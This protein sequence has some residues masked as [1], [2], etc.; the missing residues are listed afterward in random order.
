MNT[1]AAERLWKAIEELWNRI[2]EHCE[3]VKNSPF[4]F[5]ACTVNPKHS[6]VSLPTPSMQLELENQARKYFEPLDV[7]GF[8]FRYWTPP[9]LPIIDGPKVSSI[10]DYQMTCEVPQYDDAW[11]RT[12]LARWLVFCPNVSEFSS[13][14]KWFVPQI[15]ALRFTPVLYQNIQ[16]SVQLNQI[17]ICLSKNPLPFFESFV[18]EYILTD[19]SLEMS[20][21]DRKKYQQ[22]KKWRELYPEVISIFE[23]KRVTLQKAYIECRKQAPQTRNFKIKT[24]L[25]GFATYIEKILIA[26]SSLPDDLKRSLIIEL[27]Q[28]YKIKQSSKYQ[29]ARATVSLSDVEC[30]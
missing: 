16:E 27:Q 19:C 14:E 9:K 21:R 13:V 28:A 11:G 24:L 17:K 26:Q 22:E 12:M 29:A 6:R 20:S 30:G 5:G 2:N 7:I 1:S 18:G 8:Y 10:D 3:K 25:W 4:K 15:E 23:K